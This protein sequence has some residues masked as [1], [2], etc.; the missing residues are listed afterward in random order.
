RDRWIVNGSDGTL[1]Y[2]KDNDNRDGW[3]DVIPGREYPVRYATGRYAKFQG[4]WVVILKRMRGPKAFIR[5]R[6][7]SKEEL[8]PDGP[9]IKL[10]VNQDPN[11]P[12][13]A[14]LAEPGP[15]NPL[16]NPFSSEHWILNGLSNSLSDLVGGDKIAEWAWV[17][18]D[19]RR[20]SD[21]RWK[22]GAKLVG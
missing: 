21:E 9:A 11:Y 14:P 3:A 7:M 6:R 15:N 1:E 17:A 19:H 8:E 2:A 20:P 12:V 16:R 10:S 22:A 13:K 5:I 4:W 18:A